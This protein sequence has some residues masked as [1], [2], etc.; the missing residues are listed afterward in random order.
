MISVV[1]PVYNVENYIERC[2]DSILNQTYRDLEI[3]L[4][5]DGS[6]D[7]SGRICDEYEKSDSRIKVIHR[8]NGGL[9]AARNTGIKASCGEYLIFIDSDDYIHPK[10]LEILAGNLINNQSDIA[11]C[12]FKKIYDDEVTEY[13][14]KPGTTISIYSGREACLNMYDDRLAVMTVVA[15]NKLYK[16]SLFENIFY[17]EG[18]I[19]EDE[20]TTY[21]LLYN[22]GR[23]VYFDGELYYYVQRKGSITNDEVY[24]VAHLSILE[25]NDE[26][27]EFFISKD[28]KKLAN[29]AVHRATMSS[30]ALYLKYSSA[31]DSD[32]AAKAY[33][34][35]KNLKTKY[36]K[37]LKVSLDEKYL[38]S[39]FIK[40]PVTYEKKETKRN[41]IR[42][43]FEK[44][45]K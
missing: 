28:D 25:M 4:V 21:K 13:E 17:P 16:R 30:R 10:M 45:I 3:I 22:S 14:E 29:L 7:N 32:S 27:I 26:R 5:D 24:S 44:I 9:S 40:N 19:H 8:E 15:W 11:I 43:I 38:I 33:D 41:R 12:G 18:K 20:F 34:Y 36:N 1:V 39:S 23:V 31:G 2:L 6:T 35:C 37:Y 42:R